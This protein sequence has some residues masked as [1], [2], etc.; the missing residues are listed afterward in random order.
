[1]EE[2]MKLNYKMT[3][4]ELERLSRNSGIPVDRIKFHT[5]GGYLFDEPVRWNP[6]DDP[7]VRKKVSE[8]NKAYWTPERRKARSGKGNP[9][10]GKKHKPGTCNNS[11]ENNPMYGRKHSEEAKAKMRKAKKK[12]N[13]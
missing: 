8:S 5:Y 1:M 3:D 4:D 13:G 6:M 10:Y 2:N 12:N 7:E 11:G 9:F